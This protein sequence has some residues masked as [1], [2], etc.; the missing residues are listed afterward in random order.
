MEPV[1]KAIPANVAI[2]HEAS[3]RPAVPP[4]GM[5]YRNATT[6]YDEIWD[7]KEWIPQLRK[8]GKTWQ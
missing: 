3:S 5:V 7:G 2:I 8:H 6:G 4:I 1:L